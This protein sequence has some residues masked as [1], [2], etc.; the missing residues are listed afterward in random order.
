MAKGAIENAN[1]LIRKYIPK[2][3]NF[4]DFSDKTNN[5]DTEEIK[6]SS[7]RENQL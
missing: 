2:K 6:P 5:G 1:K 4:D 3:S 7:S